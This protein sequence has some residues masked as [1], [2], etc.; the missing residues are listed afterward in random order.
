[1][2]K[3]RITDDE[4]NQLEL[5]ESWTFV[6]ADAGPY[7]RKGSCKVPLNYSLQTTAPRMSAAELQEIRRLCESANS[8]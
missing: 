5:D 7:L 6:M 4:G 8:A 2:T 3:I 1:M